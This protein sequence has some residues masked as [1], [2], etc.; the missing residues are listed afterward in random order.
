M[1]ITPRSSL[2]VSCWSPCVLPGKW[3]GGGPDWDAGGA[4][5]AQPRALAVGGLAGPAPRQSCR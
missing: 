3:G 5:G 2:L 4:A 1:L